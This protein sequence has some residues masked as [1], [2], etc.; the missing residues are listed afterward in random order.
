MLTAGLVF[1]INLFD[2]ITTQKTANANIISPLAQDSTLETLGAGTENVESESLANIVNKNLSGKKGTYGV[3]ILNLKTG[4]EYF[5]NE[6][7]HFESASLYKLWVMGLVYKR[8]ENGSLKEDAVLSDSVEN[9]NR[10]FNIDSETAERKEGGITLS[11]KTAVAQM[12]SKSDNYSALL[13]TSKLGLS[14]L[15]KYLND[16]SFDD[17]KVGGADSLPETS[18]NDILQFFYKLYYGELGDKNSSEEMASVL[19]QQ[20]LNEKLPKYLPENL[21]I[22]HK[23][24]ELGT[25]SHD[26]GIVYSENGPYII[27]VLSDAPVKKTADE[28]IAQISKDVYDYFTSQ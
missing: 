9:L 25:F 13:L 28:T 3:A 10:K 19:R 26:A 21:Q 8:I 17:S 18:A 20:V 7:L 1:L 16:Y 27:V 6:H 23:T 24:G 11:L 4:E 12:I 5:E 15:Q 2:M 22:G 14:N